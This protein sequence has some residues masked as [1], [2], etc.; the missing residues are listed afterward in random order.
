MIKHC[1]V[2]HHNNFE[3]KNKIVHSLKIF[4]LNKL[5]RLMESNT[6]KNDDYM[7]YL[8]KICHMVENEQ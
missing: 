3:G 2:C 7:K 4:E 6:K 8:Y 1:L 5:I